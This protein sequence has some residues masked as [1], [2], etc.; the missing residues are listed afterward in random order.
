MEHGSMSG[1]NMGDGGMSGI[2]MQLDPVAR[3]MQ[4][5]PGVDNVAMMPI[6]RLNEA[7]DGLDGNGRRVLTYADLR[8]TQ[9]GDDPRPPSREI[10]LH[11]TGNMER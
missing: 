2:D 6:N 11:L 5:T 8:A 4:G 10:V 9:P 3:R 1:M 7:G